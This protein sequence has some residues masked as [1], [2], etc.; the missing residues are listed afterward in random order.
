[1]ITAMEFGIN[2]HKLSE[3]VTNLN[4]K[5]IGFIRAMK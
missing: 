1:M 3:T 5:I 4:H 2:K